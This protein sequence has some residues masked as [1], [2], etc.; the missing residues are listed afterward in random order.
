MRSTV[1]QAGGM[2]PKCS[3]VQTRDIGVTHY[4]ESLCRSLFRLISIVSTTK[5]SPNLILTTRRY[6]G[7][8]RLY[9]S[10][11][12][13]HNLVTIAPNRSI[14]GRVTTVTRGRH[15]VLVD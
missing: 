3:F 14:P 13:N 4:K 11:D 15:E 6:D 7:S 12:M 5:S 9:I 2:P 8:V 1:Q 10:S